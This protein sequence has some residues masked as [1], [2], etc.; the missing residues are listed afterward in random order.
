[1]RAWPGLR[2]RPRASA[3]RSLAKSPGGGRLAKVSSARCRSWRHRERRSALACSTACSPRHILPFGC[4]VP[5]CGSLLP[6]PKASCGLELVAE[7]RL[8]GRRATAFPRKASRVV[9]SPQGP[10]RNGIIDRSSSVRVRGDPDSGYRDLA[11]RIPVRGDVRALRSDVLYGFFVITLPAGVI[12][13]QRPPFRFFACPDA[14]PG[15]ESP[16]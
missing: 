12:T 14:V 11:T 7:E 8:E 15:A 5:T 9:T 10:L 13:Y 2:N 3:E 16:T 4:H 1:M 6:G